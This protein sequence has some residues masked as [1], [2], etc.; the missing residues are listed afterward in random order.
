MYSLLPKHKASEKLQAELKTKISDTRKEIEQEKKTPKKTGVSHKIPRQGAGQVVHYR[1]TVP[2]DVSAPVELR[3]R[4]RYRKFD[5]HYMEYVY[6]EGKVPDLPVVD[7]CEDAVTLPV[8]GVAG[9]VPEQ[10][11]PIPPWQPSE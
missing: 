3:V 7:L 6:G 5:H 9:E 11:S 8:Q 1:L 10:K 2:P 4:L